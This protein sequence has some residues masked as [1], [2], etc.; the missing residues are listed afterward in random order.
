MATRKSVGTHESAGS[1][2]SIADASATSAEH[3]A[4]LDFALCVLVARRAA[5]TQRASRFSGIRV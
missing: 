4:L 2:A 3:M 1:N 5:F